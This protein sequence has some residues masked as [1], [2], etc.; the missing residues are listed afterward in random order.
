MRNPF[1]IIGN[2]PVSAIAW[3]K[4]TIPLVRARTLSLTVRCTF[5]GSI[6]EDATVYLFY[7]PDGNNW[8]TIHYTSFVIAYTAGGTIQRTVIIDPPEH[9]Y[10]WAKI[11]NGSSADT[12]SNVK[13]WYTIQSWEEIGTEIVEAIRDRALEIQTQ[14]ETGQ[15]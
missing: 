8:D 10:V 2:V 9:G 12:I 6:D 11:Q 5:G 7:S 15:K 14:E 4:E 1:T 3:A 13:M